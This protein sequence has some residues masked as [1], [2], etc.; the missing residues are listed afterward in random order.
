MINWLSEF[1]KLKANAKG[2]M[3][4]IEMDSGPG[5]G[6]WAM[7]SKN[8]PLEKVSEVAQSQYDVHMRKKN[9]HV[10]GN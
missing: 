2:S 9:E 7:V 5:W 6:A 8:T 10:N 3:V 4:F 1:K